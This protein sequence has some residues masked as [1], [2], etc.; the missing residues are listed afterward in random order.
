MNYPGYDPNRGGPGAAGAW[1]LQ[2][3][4][5]RSVALSLRTCQELVEYPEIIPMP[6]IP[7]FAL[8]LLRWR[9]NWLPVLD[10]NSL[11]TGAVAGK[12]N[13][14]YCLITAYQ[15]RAGIEYGALSLKSSPVQVK[16]MDE[17][18]CALPKDGFRW[19]D[20]AISC[21]QHGRKRVPI[22]DAARIFS[23]RS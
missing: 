5:A 11:I 10:L 12:D 8:G 18:I 13:L 2:C 14:T 7:H 17:K 23:Y 1:L 16:I 20:I 22:V 9:D 6:T 21:F 4:P 15:G 19:Q 3:S